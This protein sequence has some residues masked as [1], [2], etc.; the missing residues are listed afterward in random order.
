MVHSGAISRE[1]RSFSTARFPAA[2]WSRKRGFPG[3]LAP[4]LKQAS[5]DRSV[6]LARVV[7]RQR[8]K[9]AC[10]TSSYPMLSFCSK[11]S[12]LRFNSL[13]SA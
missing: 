7:R 5:S 12:S 6:A 10:P 11:I 8:V 9:T 1:R 4:R 3:T 13:F 2:C